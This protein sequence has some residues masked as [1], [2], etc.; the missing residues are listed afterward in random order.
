MGYSKGKIAM[1]AI[2]VALIA[3]AIMVVL[4]LQSYNPSDP[5][6]NSYLSDGAP[7]Q[8]K[9]GIIGACVAD[10]ASQ[11]FGTMAWLIPL[12]LLYTGVLICYGSPLRTFAFF[13]AGFLLLAIAGSAWVNIY[14]TE[15]PLFA[16]VTAGGLTGKLVSEKLMVRFFSVYGSYVLLAAMTLCSA[17][18]L[19][20]TSLSG[21]TSK[22]VDLGGKIHRFDMKIAVWLWEKIKKV[23]N[24]KLPTFPEYEDEEATDDLRKIRKTAELDE[25]QI[26]I[27]EEPTIVDMDPED[28]PALPPGREAEDTKK[29][30]ETEFHQETLNFGDGD[31]EYIYPS[32]KLLDSAPSVVSRQ[33]KDDLLKRSMVLER[34]L[35]DFG[36]EGRVT[37]V[38]PGPV[39]TVYEFEPAPGIKVSRIVGLS[40]D[41]A[42]VLRATSIRVLA[43][44]PGKSVVGIEV[45]NPNRD[46]VSLKEILSSEEFSNSEQK[47]SI[48]LGKDVSGAPVVGNLAAVPHML[49]A[50]STGSGKSVGIN[51]M[52]CSI[53]YK[54]SPA[55]VKFIMIDPKM[56]E[57]S[58]YEGI[59]HL[60]APVVTNPKKAANALRWAVEEME[61]RYVK[62]SQL[63]VRN[64][65]SYNRRVERN[66][67]LQ[68]KTRK[69]AKPDEA[70]QD[71]NENPTEKLP[72][73]VVV[74]DELAD[75]MMVC[76]KDVEDA[77]ARLAQM[78]RAAGIHLIVATQRP[79]VDVLTGLIKANFPARLSYLVRS[80]VDSRTILDSMGA[81][82]L[83]GKGDMLYLPP[84]VSKLTRIHGPFVSDAEIHRVVDFLKDQDHPVYEEDILTPQEEVGG[85]DMIEEEA[86]EFYDKAVELV[87]TT[88]QAS[89][90]MI[91]RKFRIGYNR[92][93][94]IVEMMEAN[95][96]VG[97]ADGVKPR[98]I[99][100]RELDDVE[101][102]N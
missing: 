79:S 51:A 64:I 53:L 17:L 21:A 52:I 70:E 28:V 94:R 96:L 102:Y 46:T 84:G 76:A 33:T 15:D 24:I 19:T 95:G 59:P 91:Q 25:D 75:L 5:S 80:R 49:I 62:L 4:S 58:I 12:G 83:L 63:G 27:P 97:P 88:R 78:A 74:I 13:G 11:L 99:F 90:S 86:D 65:D 72:Y 3:S 8:N 87:A 36:I 67:E 54:A 39:I 32:I 47:L 45:P 82:K 14:W 92:A 44:I 100:I 37:Q 23:P 98:E 38:L 77:L 7:V 48:A 101:S 43:P 40:D 71:E 68:K 29:K 73:I 1:E 42:M 50:G 2:G 85:A 31:S 34:K 9:A 41:L 16:E 56:L 57:L 10:I 81:E 93:A 18:L 20:R 35:L 26:F 30:D 22:A 55:D 66:L 69:N 89:I 60:I 61:R 6:F